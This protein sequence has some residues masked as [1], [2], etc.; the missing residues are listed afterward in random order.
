VTTQQD[1][2]DQNGAP[3]SG[4]EEP[5]ATTG[6]A[7]WRLAA[8]HAGTEAEAA[9]ADTESGDAAGPDDDII[10]AEP[11]SAA[12]DTDDAE[13][14]DDVTDPDDDVVVAEGIIVAEPTSTEAGADGP[15]ADDD[16]TEPDDDVTEPDDDVVVAE[17]IDEMPA[18]RS[19][20]ADP[21]QAADEPGAG[22]S[23]PTA[24]VTGPA[25]AVHPV[26]VGLSQE[27]R[28]IQ[29]T[30]VDDPRGA[31]RLAAEATDAVLRG[32]MASLRSRQ[33]A[34]SAATDDAS[35]HR[36]TEQLRSELRQY[37]V[38]CQNLADIEQ[39]LA[40]PQAA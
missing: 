23:Q 24:D 5:T 27:W 29:A 3:D 20:L 28:D 18:Q 9:G 32:L 15:E 10:V 33:D 26:G 17:V 8:R 11:T 39:R 31:V 1:Q 25:A 6:H 21:T 19:G 16:L 37:R 14:D 2:Q 30:F 13:D 34:L 22:T 12:G 38:L 35:E 4:A 7:F 40:E 36:D